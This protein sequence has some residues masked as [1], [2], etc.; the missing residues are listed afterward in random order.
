MWAQQRLKGQHEDLGL[1]SRAEKGYGTM[2]AHLPRG[3]KP[4]AGG[5]P[6]G[7]TWM[8][9]LDGDIELSAITIPG[10]HD[11]AAFTSMFPFIQTQTLNIMQQLN[12]G[13]RYLDLRC[14]LLDNQV[15]MVHGEAILGLKLSLVLDAMYLWLASHPSEALIVQL[16]Q[17]RKSERSNVRF[18][19]AIFSCLAQNPQRWRTANT[20]PKLCELR[21]RIQLFRRFATTYPCAYGIDV[22]QWMDNPSHPFTISTKH[23]V[24][25]TVQDHY[26]F[27][28]PQPLPSVIATKG[29]N[30]SQLL[31][32][33]TSSIFTTKYRL[34][35]LQ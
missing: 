2:A 35:R 10:T 22:T 33:H 24:Q 7:E 6:V 17:D 21:G 15:E 9:S 25:V 8:S 13:I 32:L 31:D 11:S 19:Q 23:E 26:S 16:K 1:L 30:I 27:P 29:G 4:V 14:G 3:V 34:V 5:R 28:D 12:A 18:A 20:T